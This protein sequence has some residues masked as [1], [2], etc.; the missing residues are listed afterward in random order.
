MR[1]LV[2]YG[3]RIKIP[4]VGVRNVMGRGLDIPLEGVQ[5]ATGG[6]QYSIA[7]LLDSPFKKMREFDIPWV[8]ESKYHG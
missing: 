5:Y 3:K 1:G 6:G 4:W 8:R 2:F 7:I